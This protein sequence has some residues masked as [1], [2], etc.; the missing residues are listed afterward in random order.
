[1]RLLLIQE[2][3]PAARKKY[4]ELKDYYGALSLYR[5]LAEIAPDDVVV[6]AY[7]GRCHARL[8]HWDDADQGFQKAI[9]MAERK[10]SPSWWIYRDWGHIKARFN[11]YPEAKV[12][13]NKAHVKMRDHPSINSSLAFIYWQEDNIEEARELFEIAINS[14]RYHEYTL[15][16]YSRFLDAVEEH[17]YAD[18]LRERLR[19]IESGEKY[20]EPIEYDSDLDDL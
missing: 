13:L 1:M 14:N 15:E 20:V 18:R 19:E 8:K 9:E 11:F 2:I 6:L 7:I 12:L 10:G 17:E 4:K 16:H 3:T 5:L